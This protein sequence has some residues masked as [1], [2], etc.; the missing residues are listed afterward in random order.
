MNAR[1]MIGTDIG[2]A[3]LA[4]LDGEEHPPGT[5]FVAVVLPERAEAKT[6]ALPGVLSRM[7]SYA[8]ITVLDLLRKR[9]AESA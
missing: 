7:R 4:P 2:V 9:L 6:V 1:E 5:V 3:A 8:V